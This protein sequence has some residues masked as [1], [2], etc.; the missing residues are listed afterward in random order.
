MMILKSAWYVGASEKVGLNLVS[1]GP[2]TGLK[3]SRVLRIH[4]FLPLLAMRKRPSI[5]EASEKET[6]PTYFCSAVYWCSLCLA[7]SALPQ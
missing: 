1:L 2:R 5:S 3:Y 4:L 7:T 6:D